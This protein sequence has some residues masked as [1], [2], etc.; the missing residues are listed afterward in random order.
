MYW[1]DYTEIKT[2]FCFISFITK[3]HG[4]LEF[5][6]YSYFEKKNLC[7]FLMQLAILFSS[8]E[9]Q[10]SSHTVPDLTMNDYFQV[11]GG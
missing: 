10:K 11:L 8:L 3:V 4:I 6:C 1:R 7:D 9:S 5:Y 2:Y